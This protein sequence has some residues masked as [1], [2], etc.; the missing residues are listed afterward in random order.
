MSVIQLH[1]SF[2]NWQRSLHL[3]YLTLF[4]Q[5]L[6]LCKLGHDYAV[7]KIRLSP[8]SGLKEVGK[9][10]IQRYTVQ[11]SCFVAANFVSNYNN[12]FV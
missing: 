2:L 7:A 5:K 9:Y 4:E 8:V 6:F 3:Q 12:N 11:T 10:K 1:L